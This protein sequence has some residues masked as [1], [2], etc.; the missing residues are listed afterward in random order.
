MK[1]ASTGRKVSAESFAPP[2]PWELDNRHGR[3][4]VYTRRHI[5][6]CQLTD[7]NQQHCPCPKWLYVKPAGLPRYR[8]SA[9]T[10]SFAEACEIA[11]RLWKGMD[12]EIREARKIMAPVNLG[13]GIEQAIADYSEVLAARHCAPRYIDNVRSFFRRRLPPKHKRKPV[14]N[15]SLLDFLDRENLTAVTPITR[16][17]QIDSAVLRRWQATWRS[18][19]LTCGEWVKQTRMLLDWLFEEGLLESKKPVI[20]APNLIVGNR[21]GYFTD[22]QYERLIAG[23][24]FFPVPRA[25]NARDGHRLPLANYHERLRAFIEAGREGGM[26]II[27]I[28]QFDPARSLGRDNVLTFR[29]H[30]NRTK[31]TSPFATVALERD[32]AARLRSIPPE[33]GSDP[34][35][36]FR[37]PDTSLEVNCNLWRRRFQKLCYFVGIKKIETEIGVTKNPHPHMLRDTC[38]IGAITHGV[39]LE[40]VAKVLGH[41]TTAQTQRS[42][43]FWTSKRLDSCVEDQRAALA[44]RGRMN[45]ATSADAAAPG[46]TTEPISG[47]GNT[48]RTL[49]H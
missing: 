42:Y 23:L 47:Q 35:K 41:S 1:K 16:V 11:Q 32:V 48:R 17:K 36:P 29:R 43:L 34:A 3:V 44:R 6:G 4:R 21:C 40:N 19:D 20:E 46:D 26:A 5:N 14:L 28:V 30:K 22:E 12:P 2:A 31:P 37:F 38:A 24:P 33:N 25:G 7:E 9:E 45:V 27:D 15:L 13:I 18:N 8:I 49:V 39:K 10:P